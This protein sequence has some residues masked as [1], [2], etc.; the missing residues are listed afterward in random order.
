MYH[1]TALTL[2]VQHY[3][4]YTLCTALQPLNSL[5][6]TTALTL[7]CAYLSPI[8]INHS[9]FAFPLSVP[10]GSAVANIGIILNFLK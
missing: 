5:Y 1:T 4:P 7:S 3:R 10:H 9:K 6:S 8:K 2:S